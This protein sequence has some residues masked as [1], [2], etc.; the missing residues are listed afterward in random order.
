MEFPLGSHPL[1]LAIVLSLGAVMACSDGASTPQGASAPDRGVHP[2]LGK[3]GPD[4]ARRTVTGN[5]T[6]ALHALSGKVT[7]V[8]F[9]ATWCDPCKKSF[10]KLQALNA[11]YGSDG[12]EIV[13]VSEDDDKAGIPAFEAGLGAKFPVVWD[14]DKVIASK[15]QPK[16]MPSTFIL[17][18]R[19]TIRFVHFGYHDHEEAAI[20]REIQS[21]L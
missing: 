7:V 5:A 10:P 18:R 2:L 15:W 16:S 4:F 11:K 14:E 8:D 9:W 19:G 13:G 3:H 1:S 6:V 20:E 12:L 17:D 21:L